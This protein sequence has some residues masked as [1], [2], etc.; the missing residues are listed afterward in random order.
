MNIYGLNIETIRGRDFSWIEKDMPIR[1]EKG[2][3]YRFYEDRLRCF[4]V[5]YLLKEVLGV[6][7][8]K[9]ICILPSGKPVAPKFKE[10]SLSHS[11]DYCVIGISEEPIGVD[12][13]LMSPQNVHLAKDVYTKDEIAWMR[14]DE[15]RRF[16]ELWTLKESVMKS[17][18]KGLVLEPNTFST[19]PLINNDSILVED[20]KWF[21]CCASN[22]KYSYSICM[23][24]P[25]GNIKWVECS[26]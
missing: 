21:G 10:F 18:G 20:K 26:F 5:A 15:L 6:S 14:L 25:V 2:M 23:G 4:G 12:I 24:K 1:Y 7:T 22:D 9:D 11:G 8:E 16:H 13:E 17:T 19:I 3:R